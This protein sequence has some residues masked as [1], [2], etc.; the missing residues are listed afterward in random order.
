MPPL[1][2]DTEV[3]GRMRFPDL[4]FTIRDE[5]RE[6]SSCGAS[7]TSR[8]RPDAPDGS[9]TMAPSNS[10]KARVVIP[11]E[12]NQVTLDSERKSEADAGRGPRTSDL[13]RQTGR[14]RTQTFLEGGSEVRG[15]V[16]EFRAADLPVMGSKVRPIGVWLVQSLGSSQVS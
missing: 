11:L 3:N 8:T 10:V 16:P 6:R 15:L 9:Y 4:V 1:I 13:R 7:A 5:M 14:A 12:N 2:A